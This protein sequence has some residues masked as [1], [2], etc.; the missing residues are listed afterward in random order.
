MRSV[1]AAFGIGPRFVC[2]IDTGEMKPLK[3]GIEVGL[4]RGYAGKE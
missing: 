1:S 4:K 2:F 3:T